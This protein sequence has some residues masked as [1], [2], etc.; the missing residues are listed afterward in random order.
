MAPIAIL[1]ID[2]T[3]V[4][5]NYQH[6]IAWYRA[7]RAHGCTL[8]VW[9]IHRHIG[10]GGDR[11]VGALAGDEVERDRG[12]AIREDEARLYGELIGEVAALDGA[13]E[14]IAELTHRGHRVLLASSAKPDE[15]E[16]YVD[17]LA[18]RDVVDGWTT[19]GDVDTTKPAP[20]VVQA[21]LAKAGGGDAVMVGDSTWDA[22]AA[23]RA[24]I[25]CI[26]VLTGGYSG[27]ELR[28]AGASRIFSSLPGLVGELDTTPLGA[29][30]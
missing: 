12:D 9:Q 18:A 16:R 28:E 19:S 7:F 8:P 2:G 24:G 13:G 23:G 20:D 30:G 26:G 5:S 21:A 22:L 3:L 27:Q 6:A 15:V 1:D 11:L 29:A 4:D 17:L 25:P 10:M 14:L